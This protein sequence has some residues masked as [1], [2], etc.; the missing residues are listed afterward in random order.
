M[1]QKQP[2]GECGSRG[3]IHWKH[4]SQFHIKEFET[5]PR[6]EKQQNGVWY[7]LYKDE[8]GRPQRVSLRTRNNNEADVKYTRLLENVS[9]GV[10]GFEPNPK[11]YPFS[12]A[13]Q[14]YLDDGTADLAPTTLQ[15]YKEALNNHLKPYF[16]TISLRAIN[17]RQVL[18]Y[19]RYR[20]KAKAAPYTLLKRLARLRGYVTVRT[21]L[22]GTPMPRSPAKREQI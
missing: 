22:S 18:E 21:T 1:G 6:K 13:V 4:C 10:L 8:T 14:R 5:W 11:A 2:C 12:E 15:R 3:T 9:K 20:R 17:P 19:I 16:K 7:A